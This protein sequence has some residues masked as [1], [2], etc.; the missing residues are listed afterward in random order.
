MSASSKFASLNGGL[1]R[2][3]SDRLIVLSVP[4]YINSDCGPLAPD[5]YASGTV[6]VDNTAGKAWVRGTD[7]DGSAVWND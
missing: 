5:D 6:W 1:L 3:L 7:A 4:T 2:G